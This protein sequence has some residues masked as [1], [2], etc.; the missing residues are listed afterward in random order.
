MR[1]RVKR[2]R[3]GEFRGEKRYEEQKKGRFPC[4]GKPKG[5]GGDHCFEYL[6]ETEPGA[7]EN[8]TYG[9]CTDDGLQIRRELQRRFGYTDGT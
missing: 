9:R 4:N 8:I 1:W 7:G 2:N 6:Y 5:I 3:L